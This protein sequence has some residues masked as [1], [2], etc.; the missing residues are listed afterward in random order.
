MGNITNTDVWMQELS[1]EAYTTVP[2]RCTPCTPRP[3]KGGVHVPRVV[4][5]PCSN[6][7]SYITLIYS[8]CEQCV[9]RNN[10]CKKCTRYFLKNNLML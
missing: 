5:R 2:S 9:K 6:R 7:F 1:I 8:A 10:V 4:R 3:K